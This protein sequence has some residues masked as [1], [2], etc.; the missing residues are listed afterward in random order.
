VRVRETVWRGNRGEGS[1]FY[2]LDRDGQRISP[3]LYLAYVA[4]SREQVKSAMTANLDEAKKLL[5]E[6]IFNR[7]AAKRGL[8]VLRTPKTE[9]LTVAQLVKSYLVEHGSMADHGRPVIAELGP[10][11][12]VD[13]SP[14]HVRHYKTARAA[15]VEPSTIANELGVLR[16][17]YRFA[18]SE[19]TL[20]HVPIIKLPAFDNARKVFFPLERIPELIAVTAR[21]NPCVSDFFAWQSFSGMR[22]K[23]IAR[24]KWS[25]LDVSDWVLSLDSRKDKSKYGRELA[26]EGESRE[27]FERR[28]AARRPG[29]V[30][31]FGGREQVSHSMLLRTWNRAL[32]EM[33]LPTGMEAGFVPYDLKKTALRAIRRAGVPEE[34]AMYFSGHRTARTFRRYDVTVNEDNREDVARVTAYRKKR[35]SDNEGEKSDKDAKLLRIS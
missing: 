31:I 21:M 13:L 34:R 18:A 32:A 26:I 10:V 30:Y 6:Y 12:V 5:D 27:I 11:K 3:N 22:P 35:F 23:A 25:D 4:G 2:R 29:D 33:G 1:V 15:S 9:R 16:A 14:E 7:K 20:R 19:G 24:L 28:R 8:D 17:A